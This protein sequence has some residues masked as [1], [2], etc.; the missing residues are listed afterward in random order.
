MNGRTRIGCGLLA[1]VVACLLAPSV[2]TAT[3]CG[4]PGSAGTGMNELINVQGDLAPNRTG[5]YL[6][7]PFTGPAGTKGIQV[8]YSYDQPGGGCGGSPNTLDMGVYQPKANSSS[9]VFE[10]TDRRGWSG[11]AVKNL[12]ISENGFTTEGVYNP[13][14]KAFVDGRTTR[15]YRPGPIQVGEWAVEL[16]IAY[17]DPADTDGAHFH[18]QVLTSNDPIWSNAQYAPSGPPAASINSTPGWYT[19]DLHVHGEQEPGNATMTD[20]FAAAFGAGGAGLDFVTLVDHNNNIAHSDMKTQADV[21]PDNLVIPGVEVTTYKGHW[22]NQGSSAFADFRGGPVFTENSPDSQIDDSELVQSQAAA[23]PKDQFAAAQAGGGWTQ[24]NHPATYKDDPSGCRGCAWT[25]SDADTDFSKVDAIEVSN[26]LGAL[27]KGPFTLDA[28][29]YYEHALDTGAH[30]AAIGSSDAHKAATDVISHVG[31]GVTVVH[32]EGLGRQA[33]ID[34]VKADHTYVKPFGA[35]G[36]DVTL[37]ATDADGDQAIIGDSIDGRDV[38]LTATVSGIDSV[39]PIRTGS[40]ELDLLQDGVVIDS[41]PITGAGI[42]QEYDVSESGRYA[43]EVTRTSD[44][45]YIEDYTSPVWV[46]VQ[47]KPSNKFTVGKPKIDKKKGTAKL[48]V[49][50]PGAGKLKLTGKSIA[51]AKASPAKASTVK[52]PVKPVGKL[53]KKLRRKGKAKVE[54]TVAFT[55]TGGDTAK[56]TKS[57]KLV[58]K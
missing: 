56:K 11:S 30:I 55:P 54:V 46:T 3:D 17:I 38:K 34:G 25:Y 6:Q 44:G 19:G 29:A 21:Y 5:G 41:T 50:V 22:N 2:A 58:R 1:G 31:E 52:L 48:P 20:T 13:N 37:E 24:I 14:K 4:L 43:I 49:E 18:L 23:L 10:Q 32:A 57:V 42:S 15:A 36:P 9:P 40:W 7:I 51:D 12:A 33:I 39:P 27:S 35:T 8:R 28:I 45:T 26:S 53:K 47:P 16:G